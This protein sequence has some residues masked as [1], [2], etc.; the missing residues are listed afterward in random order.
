M[1]VKP[2]PDWRD[3]IKDGDVLLIG[4]DYR[5][6]RRATYTTK[7][8][9]KTL[10]AVTLAIRRCS[11]TK[12]P[13]TV[14]SRS[15]LKCRGFRPT[16]ITIKRENNSTLI[17]DLMRHIDNDYLREMDCCLVKGVP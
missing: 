3:N 7:H 14:V 10:S 15:D 5:V 6:V 2:V 13:Y 1:T 16:G 8:G 17:A 12:R 4:N 9:N 11:W